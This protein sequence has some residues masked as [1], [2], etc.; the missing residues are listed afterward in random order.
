[1]EK[2]KDDYE[3]VYDN[4]EKI[5][6]MLP[7]LIKEVD[8]IQDIEYMRFVTKILIK[9]LT[10]NLECLKR[11]TDITFSI[12]KKMEDWK[13]ANNSKRQGNL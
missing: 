9:S 6:E 5:R 2:P 7:T 11:T 3:V 10:L 4:F 12:E 13:D 1:M 8:T